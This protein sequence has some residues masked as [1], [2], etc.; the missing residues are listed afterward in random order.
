[1]IILIT[2]KQQI[3]WGRVYPLSLSLYIYIYIY[4]SI[5]HFFPLKS[6]TG[7]NQIYLYIKRKEQQTK[8]IYIL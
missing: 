6:K 7:G 4:I 2:V 1:M 8:K 5:N 3:T